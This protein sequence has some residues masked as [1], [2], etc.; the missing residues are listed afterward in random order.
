MFSLNENGN[1]VELG[2]KTITMYGICSTDPSTP[3]K[4]VTIPD[5]SVIKQGTT[6]RIKF[7]NS[8]YAQEPML[9]VNDIGP[10]PIYKYGQTPPGMTS[11]TSWRPDSIIQLT[12]DGSAWLIDGQSVSGDGMP[13]DPLPIA[14]GGTGNSVGYIRTGLAEF[15]DDPGLCSTAE[16]SGVFSTG[17]YSHAEGQSTKSTGIDSH[18][19]GQ[20][21][22]AI[23]DHSHAEGF[24]TIAQGL[25]SHASGSQ[26]IAPNDYETVI[27]R[28]N[29]GKT[30]NLFE[31]GNGNG[32]TRSNAFEVHRSGDVKI[33]GWLTDKDGT[34]RSVEANPYEEATETLTKL[35]V[36]SDVYSI[37][38][39]GSLPEDPLSI[40]HGGTGNSNGFIQTGARSDSEIGLYATAEG[41]NNVSSG[42]C[43]HSEGS[44]TT[45]SGDNSHA[46]GHNTIANDLGAHAEGW[47]TEA[48]KTAH[49]EGQYN[50]A[51]GEASHAGGEYSNATGRL[52]FVHGQNVNAAANNQFA[53]GTYND[54]KIDTIFELG[55]GRNNVPSNA[56]EVYTD[57]RSSWDNG[58]TKFK[59]TSQDGSKGYIDENGTFNAFGSGGGGLP[60]NPL[61]IAHGGTGNSEGYI[62]TGSASGS[63]IGS[64]ATV[65][66]KY[67]T[68]SGEVSHVE[69]AE[70]TASEYAAHAEGDTNV[71][72]GSAS[73]VEG[74]FNEATEACSHAEGN[75]TISSGF[76]S[77][78]EG[79]GYYNGSDSPVTASGE[80]A[81]AE[82]CSTTASGIGSHSEGIGTTASGDRAHAEGYMNTASNADC[83]VEGYMNTASKNQAHAEGARNVASGLQSH[84]GGRYNIA[85]YDQQTV[86]GR[87]NSNKQSTLFEVGNG[88]SDNAGVVSRSNAFE[89]HDDG[90][91]SWDNGITLFKFTAQNGVK[92][93][94]DEN[95]VFNIIP[96]EVY[97]EQ[98]TTLSTSS[99]TTLIFTNSAIT[100]SSVVQL[101]IAEWGLN[102]ENVTVEDGS[103]TIVMPQVSSAHSVLVGIYIKQRIVTNA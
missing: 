4:R 11:T 68:G 43:S 46:E 8:N 6:I 77:H 33:A 87:C 85:A 96:K 21:T 17:S 61:S 2:G 71:A 36:G 99:T 19:E 83:H 24:K 48:G 27:G 74:A 64:K 28:L 10:K 32:S 81:H 23:G 65:E 5:L 82:G 26:T 25:A 9:I 1:L 58:A 100:E 70:N 39:G 102:P 84:V 56:F 31:I 45:A 73:H 62:R 41:N 40:V 97:L 3:V 75:S 69:G 12:Y 72:S 50:V 67:N 92:G 79:V 20:A 89:I 44:Y 90:S 30:G 54:N 7:S 13:G 37:S 57:G 47:R 35:K 52:S 101:A 103:C 78:T 66:G 98:T 76:A 34:V 16:G 15:A 80:G 22:E 63:Q 49:A 51:S 95:G 93:Y 55:N 29:V 38:S 88:T 86:I 42:S 14:H 18:A 60:E 53:V 59:F 94:I 91:A